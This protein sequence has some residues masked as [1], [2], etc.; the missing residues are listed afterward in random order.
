MYSL[1]SQTSSL[2]AAFR[3]V[4]LSLVLLAVPSSASADLIIEIADGSIQPGG[5]A[6]A[7]VTIRTSDG[8]DLPVFGSF[9]LKF[10][11]SAAAGVLNFY[12]PGLGAE[13]FLTDPDYVFFSLSGAIQDSSVFWVPPTD[14]GNGPDTV[15]TGSDYNADI[16]QLPVS[17]SMA[18]LARLYLLS[19]VNTS[20]GSTAVISITDANV[21]DANSDPLLPLTFSSTATFTVTPEPSALALLIA[22]AVISGPALIRKARRRASVDDKAVAT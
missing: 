5:T 9:D 10:A 22:A 17:R 1:C 19:D 4:C 2:F 14:E 7:D 8:T 3:H 21:Y 13:D 11:I 6:T 20:V 18:L 15:I 16:A 12:A